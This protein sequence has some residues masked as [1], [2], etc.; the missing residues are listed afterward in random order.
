MAIIDGMLEELEQD[1]ET[2]RRVLEPIPDDQQRWRPHA[3]VRTLDE[4]AMHVAIVPGTLAQLYGP[5]ARAVGAYATIP[6]G[7]D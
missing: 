1:A 4:L 5:S 2:T 7:Y 3:K 6:A